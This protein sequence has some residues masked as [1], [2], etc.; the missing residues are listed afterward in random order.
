MY[1]LPHLYFSIMSAALDVE[2]YLLIFCTEVCLCLFIKRNVLV[3]CLCRKLL[4]L[5]LLC[6]VIKRM[7]A[8]GFACNLLLIFEKIKSTP[9]K[10]TF[11]L[12]SWLRI[13]MLEIIVYA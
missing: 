3:P 7:G 10:F 1:L 5:K 9:I 8:V 6:Q 12:K 13:I 2:L 11:Q 4:L